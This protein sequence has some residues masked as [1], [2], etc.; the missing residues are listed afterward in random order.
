MIN[1]R[2]KRSS[3]I[4]WGETISVVPLQIEILILP[5]FGIYLIYNF[6]NYRITQRPRFVANITIGAIGD[7]KDL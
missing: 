3:G 6:I 2:S 1:N 5:M 7:S 4:P